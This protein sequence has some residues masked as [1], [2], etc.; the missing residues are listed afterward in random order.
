MDIGTIDVRDNTYRQPK[1]GVDHALMNGVVVGLGARPGPKHFLRK[2]FH[3]WHQESMRQSAVAIRRLERENTHRCE[4]D[5]RAQYGLP[6][7][8]R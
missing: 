7:K 4:D 8:S 1:G 3:Q 5:L 2:G 6:K